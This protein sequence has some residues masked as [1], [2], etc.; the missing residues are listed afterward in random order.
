MFINGSK[1]YPAYKVRVLCATSGVGNAGI[2]C[3]DVRIVYRMD[4]P[5]SLLDIAQENGC[6]GRRPDAMANDVLF[7]R[8][9]SS[10]LQTHS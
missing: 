1:T 8:L 10:S 7:T 2:D 9:S 4:F 6:A 3:R 5:P